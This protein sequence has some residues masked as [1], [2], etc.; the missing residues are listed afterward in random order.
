M[1]AALLKTKSRRIGVIGA[2][3][4]AQ[5]LVP[6]AHRLNLELW[7]QTANPQDPAAQVADHVVSGIPELV[8]ACDLVT[9]EN[10]FVDLTYLQSLDPSKFYPRLG[11]LA[12]LLDKYHQR[13]FLQELGIPVPDFS[14]ELPPWPLPWVWKRRRHGYDGQGTRILTRPETWDWEQG[15]VERYIPFERELATLVAR[16]LTGEVVHY[17]VVETVQINQVCDHVIAPALIPTN[18]QEQIQQ[19]SYTLIEALEWVGIL[20]I[21]LFLTQEQQL[22]VN[23]LAPRTHN[24]GHYSLDACLT[25]QFEQHLRAITGLPLGSADLTC[26]AALMVNLLGWETS[27]SSYEQ[28]RQALGSLPR[29]FVHWYGKG[30]SRPGRKLGHVTC[31]LEDRAEVAPTLARVRQLWSPRAG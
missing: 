13:C 28:E 5:M 14:L 7:V 19:I 30:E 29:T 4:L 2:G 12:P 11:S 1:T 25:S 22:L 3:Q 27:T 15:M 21:E 16:S 17:P 31:L 6:A 8:T 9:F 10:E 26:G 18:L 23:E 24:S 20:A